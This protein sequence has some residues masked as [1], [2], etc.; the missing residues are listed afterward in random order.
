ME[1]GMSGEIDFTINGHKFHGIVKEYIC[2]HI[3]S[4][5]HDGF[6]YHY[7]EEIDAIN[8]QEEREDAMVKSEKREL[9]ERKLSELF[10]CD[11][12]AIPI[13]KRNGSPIEP[14][15]CWFYYVAC[16]NCGKVTE[17][18]DN[19]GDAQKAWNKG[20]RDGIDYNPYLT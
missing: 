2:D 6:G 14:I 19:P 3:K 8:K 11:C 17:K 9:E 5:I 13:P 4:Q 18:Y 20:K 16:P 7:W 1:D 10:P 15:G 12:G